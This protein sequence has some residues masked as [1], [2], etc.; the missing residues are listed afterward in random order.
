M[1]F[2]FFFVSL[3]L[4]LQTPVVVQGITYAEKMFLILISFKKTRFFML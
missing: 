3:N 1:N 2:A 4:V